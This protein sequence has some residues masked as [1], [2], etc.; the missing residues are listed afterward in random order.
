VSPYGYYGANL[1]CE[2]IQGGQPDTVAK[3]SGFR[4]SVVIVKGPGKFRMGTTSQSDDD[5]RWHEATEAPGARRP[6][7]PAE[8]EFARELFELHRL[9][10]YRYLVGLLPTKDDAREVLQETYLRLLRQRSFDHI[11]ANA[12]AY[13][14]QIATNLA[15]DLFRQRTH[16]AVISRDALRDPDTTDWSRWPDLEL[17]GEQLAE[18]MVAALEQLPGPMREALLLYR[19]RDMTHQEIAAHM[20]L[21]TRTV[22]RYIKDGLAHIARRLQEVS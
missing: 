5:E 16:R 1:A 15:R 20:H 4:R 13:L 7:T 10:L 17:T 12:R 9:S 8:S 2:T 19:F 22:E 11:R 3:L 6:L 21:S 18:I 14:F